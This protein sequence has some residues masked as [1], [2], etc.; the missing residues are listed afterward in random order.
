MIPNILALILYS[1][2]LAKY[3]AVTVRRMGSKRRKW[4]NGGGD[5]RKCRFLRATSEFLQE[6]VCILKDFITS[7][8]KMTEIG[9]KTL[10]GIMIDDFFRSIEDGVEAIHLFRN[11]LELFGC[12]LVGFDD[13]EGELEEGY[14]VAGSVAETHLRGNFKR[15]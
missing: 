4:G 3:T 15:N 10:C 8:G 9:T 5:W 1:K 7:F 13:A 14:E 6:D 12:V 11:V 2:E